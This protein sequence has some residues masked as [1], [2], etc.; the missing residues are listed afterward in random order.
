MCVCRPRPS[1]HTTMIKPWFTLKLRQLHQA[2]EEA[3]S[4]G[5]RALNRQARNSLGIR[6][7]RRKASQPTIL[8]QFK[9][10]CRTLL[11]TDDHPPTLWKTLT[12]RWPQ[13]LLHQ[14][15]KFERNSFTPIP[16]PRL[17]FRQRI[18]RKVVGLVQICNKTR[19]EQMI[20]SAQKNNWGQPALH[21]G[22]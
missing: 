20:G 18:T 6:V 9:E 22:T 1:A 13:H 7:A 21:T 2:K 3:C 12:G 19:Q 17:L 11:T 10:A 15:W 4:S 16:P 5:D 8:C 14:V